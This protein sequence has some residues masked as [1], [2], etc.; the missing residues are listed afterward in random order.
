MSCN[1]CLMASFSYDDGI[2]RVK[3]RLYDIQPV[4]LKSLEIEKISLF[5]KVAQKLNNNNL[6]P[7]KIRNIIKKASNT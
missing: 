3:K 7:L 2:Q 1:A 6:R 5:P 4:I